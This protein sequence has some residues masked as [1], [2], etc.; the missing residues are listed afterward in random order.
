M[1]PIMKLVSL[2]IAILAI[3]SFAVPA[4]AIDVETPKRCTVCH[5]ASFQGLQPAPR[6]AG[7]RYQYL[8]NQLLD[9][10]L[11][12]RD[13]PNAK[14]F[15]WPVVSTLNPQTAHEL[16]L[17]LSTIPPVAADDGDSELV[18]SGRAIYQEGIPASNVVACVACHG[19]NAEGVGEIPRLG[20]LAYPYL[21]RRLKQWGHLYNYAT[22]PPMPHIASNLS[23][24][25]ITAL[26]SY[27]SFV[28]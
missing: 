20:G 14:L 10:G 28:K 2:N 3:I 6:L 17:Y 18:A 8:F 7:Q 21:V 23:P 11:H 19:P 16:A 13:D 27:L 24:N 9:L 22:R 26:A 5:S 4:W 25:E 1:K 12:R 15:M